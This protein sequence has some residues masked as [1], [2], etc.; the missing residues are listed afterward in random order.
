MTERLRVYRAEPGPPGSP[1]G[2]LFGWDDRHRAKYVLEARHA[3]IAV[4]CQLRELGRPV[5]VWTREACRLP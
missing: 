1:V 2:V 4:A 3:V 5:E